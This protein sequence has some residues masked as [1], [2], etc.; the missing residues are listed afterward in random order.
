MKQA[1]FIPEFLKDVIPPYVTLF[2]RL[3]MPFELK[4]VEGYI[5]VGVDNFYHYYTKE[6]KQLK[7]RGKR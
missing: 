1:D 5:L 2:K 6:N 3:S 4:D 7:K